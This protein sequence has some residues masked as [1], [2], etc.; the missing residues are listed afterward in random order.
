M[1][2]Q[3][4]DIESC[5]TKGIFTHPFEE[6]LVSGEFPDQNNTNIT[7]PLNNY[8]DNGKCEENEDGVLKCKPAAGSLA[9]LNDGRILYFNALEGTEN[10]E[11]NALLEIGSAII[12]DQTRVL[13]MENNNASW[14]APSPVDAGANPDGNDS[15]TLIGDDNE[16]FLKI[17]NTGVFAN[18]D[19]PMWFEVQNAGPRPLPDWVQD[20][21]LEDK[22]TQVSKNNFYGWYEHR[23]EKEDD[24]SSRW[25]IAI[26]VDG[27]R[28]ALSGY[29]KSLAPPTKRTL[30]TLDQNQTAIKDLKAMVIPSA[31]SAIRVS[32]SGD[33]HMVVL[34][35]SDTPMLR[36]SP[37]EVEA[38]T[39]SVGW[40]QLG[41]EPVQSTKSG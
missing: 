22:W 12:N 21:G 15:E 30:V 29:F 18:W 24:H 7:N 31:Q 5:K 6:P 1:T 8:P 34:D 38:N 40:K 37:H 33:H 10:V 26:I 17:T 4:A 16:A 9:L 27:T 14:I 11:Y 25:D 23:L 35:A 28:S 19:H 2:P 13:T 32:Y 39:R 41:R 3:C 20:G 36:F